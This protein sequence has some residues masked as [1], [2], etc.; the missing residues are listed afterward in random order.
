M[1]IALHLGAHL[2][3]DGRLQGCLSRNADTLAQDGAA[4]PDPSSYRDFI[5]NAIRAHADGEFAED[6]GGAL[7]DSIT[8][9]DSTRRLV[10][11]T[12]RFLSPLPSAV[13]GAQ[14]CP[15]ASTRLDGLR[16]L[17]DGHDAQLFL[18]IRNPASFVPAVLQ[19][20][21]EDKA[22]AIRSDLR[23][24]E[25]RWSDLVGTIRTHFPNAPL[26]VWCDE[27]T[28][29]IWQR[30]LQRVSDHA[31]DTRLAHVHDWFET[32]MVDGGAA[33]LATYM[34]NA[35]PM[36]DA[37]HQRVISAFLD[38]FC[39]PAK[40][41]V[42]VSAAGWDSEMVDLLSELYDEDV[43]TLAKMDGVTLLQP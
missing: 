15:M 3:D 5:L 9:S 23:P 1:E 8:P 16:A 12:P 35:P 40:I 6:A 30:V 22:R 41:D 38:K 4:C 34:D 39:D 21:R 43:G 37:Q 19:S 18:A 31:P 26:T 7:L 25:L 42:D 36:D 27:D 10:L 17:F 33:K 14:L 28:P 29:F 13:R 20:I 24:T 2:T 32:V 11:S